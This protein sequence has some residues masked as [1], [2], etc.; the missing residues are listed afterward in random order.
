[1]SFV[2]FFK[3]VGKMAFG[4]VG[5]FILIILGLLTATTGN[6]LPFGVV[7]FILGL[8]VALYGVY[9]DRNM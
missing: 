6:N 8:I 5:G 2:T 3:Q 1:M 4:Y 7:L 9:T